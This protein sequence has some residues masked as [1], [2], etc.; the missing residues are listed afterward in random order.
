MLCPHF[1]VLRAGRLVR[2]TTPSEARQRLDGTLFEGSIEERELAAL[3]Q[4]YS[5]TQAFSRRGPRAR[6]PSLPEGKPPS[7]FERPPPLSR[8]RS[9]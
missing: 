1:A 6:T 8:M 5:V 3:Y 4:Q 7:G 9:S 2:V